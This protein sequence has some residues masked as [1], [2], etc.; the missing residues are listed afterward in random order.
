VAAHRR[1]P[2][3]L[4]PRRAAADD[5][6]PALPGRRR[7]DGEVRLVARR[8]VVDAADHGVLSGPHHAVLVA[9]DA[10]AHRVGPPLAEP[11][12]EVGVGDERPGHLHRVGRLGRDRCGGDGGIDEAAGGEDGDAAA[13]RAHRPGDLDRVARRRVHSRPGGVD[14][15]DGADHHADPVDPAGGEEVGGDAGSLLRGDPRPGRELVG[16]E[17][18][19]H[20]TGRPDG[21]A[22][23]G[24]DLAQEARTALQ[25]SPVS[26]AA[27]VGERGEELAEQ[28]VL[29]GVHLDPVEPALDRQPG[30]AGEALDQ[31]GDVLGL[32]HLGHLH[33]RRVGHRRGRPHRLPARMS[34]ALHPAVV[35]LD[36]EQ[37][38]V[39]SH[40]VG[41]PRVGGADGGVVAA[42][43]AVEGVVAGVDAHLLDDDQPGA[44]PGA[45]GV[46][47][48]VRLA[49]QAVP[50]QVGGVGGEGDPRRGEVPAE[51]QRPEQQLEV[52]SDRRRRQPAAGV[53]HAVR[54][55]AAVCSP[56][57]ST[58][59][60]RILNFWILPVTV[61]GNS[62]T[63]FQ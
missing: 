20:Q 36:A 56:S 45:S 3:R 29:A 52:R 6:H 10:G 40:R 61:I 54:I 9:A 4:H 59:A 32:H 35:E 42:E 33:R 22:D 12:D 24:E 1:Q 63:N 37:R 49:R 60:S 11:G 41:D 44:A 53:G 28:R 25:V 57:S 58:A 46:V 19:A 27:P 39:G 34:G 2:G 8:G 43:R 13:H 15:V 7:E 16:A 62:S 17:A 5:E 18:Q 51:A 47:G 31:G 23:R 30:A 38:A 50:A 26:V 14:A 21:F 55:P 48:G